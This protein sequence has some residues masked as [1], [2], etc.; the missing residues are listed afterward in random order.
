MREPERTPSRTSTASG[1]RAEGDA[2]TNPNSASPEASNKS[3][4]RQP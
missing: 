1:E 3:E 2:Q 4:K